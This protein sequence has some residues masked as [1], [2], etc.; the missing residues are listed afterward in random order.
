MTARAPASFKQAFSVGDVVT[1]VRT[2]LASWEPEEL[3][4]IPEKCRPGPITGCEDIAA[5]A[6]NL[7]TTRID[8]TW[9]QE[10][11]VELD[12]LFARACQR[13]T[14]IQTASLHAPPAAEN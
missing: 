6:F 3:A 5:M 11:L 9:P 2:H 1:M 7:T 8:S 10:L 13:L 14:E 4:R 12:T